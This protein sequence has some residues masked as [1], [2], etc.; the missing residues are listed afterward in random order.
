MRTKNETTNGQTAPPNGKIT[1]SNG[2]VGRPNNG[3]S[4]HNN[5]C[6]SNSYDSAFMVSFLQFNNFCTVKHKK[7]K[8]IFNVY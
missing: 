7:T 3:V 4:S 2:L 5:S 8:V 6:D 1:P